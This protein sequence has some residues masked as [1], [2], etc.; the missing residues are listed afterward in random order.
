MS[1]REAEL[2]TQ[3]SAAVVIHYEV[4]KTSGTLIIYS[5]RPRKIVQ[6]LNMGMGA[7][8]VFGFSPMLFQ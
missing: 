4:R 6:F 7:Y 2:Q 1:I 8:T 3:G 5:L